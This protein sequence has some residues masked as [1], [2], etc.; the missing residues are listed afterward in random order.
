MKIDI[1]KV[2]G[3]LLILREYCK[4]QEDCDFC[5]LCDGDNP[6]PVGVP[7]IWTIRK[8]KDGRIAL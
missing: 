2:E 3:A 1:K 4:A 7:M 8:T 5:C 6:C